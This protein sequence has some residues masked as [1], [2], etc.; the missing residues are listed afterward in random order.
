MGRLFPEGEPTTPQDV[1]GRLRSRRRALR[2]M[3]TRMTL[4]VEFLFFFPHGR[5]RVRAQV[6][7]P[8]LLSAK[9]ARQKMKTKENRWSRVHQELRQMFCWTP[10]HTAPAVLRRIHQYKTW[11]LHRGS[12]DPLMTS[13]LLEHGRVHQEL[14]TLLAFFLGLLPVDGSQE[15]PKMVIGQGVTSS[16][17]DLVDEAM[18]IIY[19]HGPEDEAS[20]NEDMPSAVRWILETTTRPVSIRDALVGLLPSTYHVTCMMR[21]FYRMEEWKCPH[22]RRTLAS[23]LWGPIK[24]VKSD[25]SLWPA[26]F[27]DVDVFVQS[28]LTLTDH[29]LFYLMQALNEED[30]DVLIGR[31]K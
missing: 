29:E 18:C 23:G 2:K 20:V 12:W 25:T 13:C 30:E 9:K 21:S 6:S 11:E 17:T 27:Q 7:A 28:R 15:C 1:L 3:E 19:L 5:A 26:W 24:N 4:H 10:P 14:A 31:Q 16:L 22:C 8:F